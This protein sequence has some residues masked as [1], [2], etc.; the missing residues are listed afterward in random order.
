MHVKVWEALVCKYFYVHHLPC[1]RSMNT[2]GGEIDFPTCRSHFPWGEGNIDND[3]H[4]VPVIL[5][6]DRIR[7]LLTA[8]H[9]GHISSTLRLRRMKLKSK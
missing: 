6:V 1:Q 4:D 7:F 2:G 9:E 5:H 3:S 8:P